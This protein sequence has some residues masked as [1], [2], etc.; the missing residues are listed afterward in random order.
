MTDQHEWVRD[1]QARY[2]EQGLIP[3][4]PDDGEW[5]VCHCPKP[6][7]AGGIETIW[8][9]HKDHQVQGLLQS[10]EYSRCCFYNPDVKSFLDNSWCQDWFYLYSLY[11][12]WSDYHSRGNLAKVP[13]D[14]LVANGKTNIA[15]MPRETRVAN[16]KATGPANGKAAAET[17]LLPNCSANAKNTNSQQWRCLVTGHFSSP[18]SLSM[19]QKARGINTKLRVRVDQHGN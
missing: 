2:E 6:K 17:N 15:K 16:G 14:V 1:C 8:L 7:W 5:E 12:E 9:L 18:G 13:K 3:G 4:N 11:E 10:E 19:Y